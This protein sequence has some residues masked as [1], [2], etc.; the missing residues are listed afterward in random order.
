M[1]AYKAEIEGLKAIAQLDE[2]KIKAYIGQIEG[3]KALIETYKAEVQA[4]V[5]LI[6]GEKA[7]IEI[8]KE[9]ITAWAAKVKAIVDI[10]QG[11]VEGAKS[12]A[13]SYAAL[14]NVNVA[15]LGESV[16]AYAAQMNAQASVIEAGIRGNVD[17]KQVAVEAQKSLVTIYANIFSAMALSIST[18]LHLQGTGQATESYN[19]QFTGTL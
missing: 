10:Y 5:A 12:Y 6:E 9:R 11:Q 4:F 7:K 14:E 19:E 15:G 16:R 8:Y 2:V 17:N 13:G 1:E 3:I 18:Q